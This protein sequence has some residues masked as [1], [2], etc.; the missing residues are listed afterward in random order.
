MTSHPTKLEVNQG[1]RERNIKLMSFL[2]NSD[3]LAKLQRRILHKEVGLRSL[4]NHYNLK[5]KN[6]IITQA[7]KISLISIKITST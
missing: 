3:K 5:I 4:D 1:S 7:F 2:G 6:S